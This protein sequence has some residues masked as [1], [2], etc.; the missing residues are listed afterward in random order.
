MIRPIRAVAWAIFLFAEIGLV[1]AAMAY[2]GV[3]TWQF[4]LVGASAIVAIVAFAVAIRVTPEPRLEGPT[5][6]TT[7]RWYWF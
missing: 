4:G 7:Q 1:A 5:S 6:T 3:R 2:V